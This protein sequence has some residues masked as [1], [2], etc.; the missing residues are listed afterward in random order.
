[1]NKIGLDV[2]LILQFAYF[3]FIVF[4]SVMVDNYIVIYH[5]QFIIDIHF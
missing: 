2:L 4:T 3:Q 1:M 5:I